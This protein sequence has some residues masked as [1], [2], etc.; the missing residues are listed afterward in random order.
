MLVRALFVSSGDIARDELA[1]TL[2]INIHRMATPAY[3]KALGILLA[4]LTDQVS[5]H[6]QTG[7]KVIFRLV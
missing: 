1:N 5:C 4:D 7:A 2:T 3:D 6:P